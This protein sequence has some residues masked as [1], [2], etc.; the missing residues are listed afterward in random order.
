MSQGRA[1]A[2]TR[3]SI[4]GARGKD[5]IHFKSMSR[6]RSLGPELTEARKDRE[7]VV[8]S[9]YAGLVRDWPRTP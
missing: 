3:Q 1:I 7:R 6:N 9:D 4:V 5:T 8:A 2:T